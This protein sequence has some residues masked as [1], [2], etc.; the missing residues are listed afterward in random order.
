MVTNFVT[1]LDN[2]FR[3]CNKSS[4][5]SNR[6][7]TASNR[8]RTESVSFCSGAVSICNNSLYLDLQQFVLNLWW[9]FGKLL[10]EFVT[11]LVTIYVQTCYARLGLFII[12]SI[13]RKK[14]KK[15]IK[16]RHFNQSGSWFTAARSGFVMVRSRFVSVLSAGHQFGPIL[17]RIGLHLQ[18]FSLE[19]WH[20]GKI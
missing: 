7:R 12:G 1:N 16:L 4:T 13:K 8:A 10:A 14:R 20:F 9:Q 3:N 6:D 15:K 19:L 17:W 2:D 5:A 18:K 11:R